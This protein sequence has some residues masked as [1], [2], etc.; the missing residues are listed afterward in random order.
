MTERTMTG[1]LAD[2]A[3]RHGSEPA[4]RCGETTVTFAGL[5]D[6]ARRVAAGLAAHGVGPGDR[7]ALWLPNAPAY[8]ALVFACARLGAIAVAVNTRFR[9]AEVEDIVGRSRAKA[10]VLWPGF[11]AIDFLGIL[12]A[13]DPDALAALETVV[14]YDEGDAAPAERLIGRTMV[15]YAELAAHGPMAEDFATPETGVAVFTTSGTTSKPKFVLHV[16]RSLTDHG[17][18]AG[19]ALGY[20]EADAVMLQALPLCGVF[21][22]AQAMATLAAARPMVLMPV[23]SGDEAAAAIE[24]WRVTHMN[25]SDEM[26]WRIF[27]AQD[28]TSR[29]LGSLR[30]CG[31][32]AFNTDPES[33]V[34]EADRRGVPAVGLYGMSE[35][36]ALFAAR[37]PAAPASERRKGGGTPVSDLARVRAR[38]PETGILRPDGE[39]GELE[40]TGPSVFAEYLDDPDAT[41]R[42][43]T[44]D[45][46]VRTGDLG[47]TEPGGGFEFLSRMGDV[48]RLGG[49]LV[50]PA[51][52]TA[53]LER[54]PAVAEAQAVG[55][56]A[57][58]G[59][60]V[61]AF[62]IPAPGAAFDE[63][64]LIAHCR[65]GMARFKVP[66][67]VFAV[68]AFPMA[69]SANGMKIQR[70]KLR[71][72]A[73]EADG[74]TSPTASSASART[75]SMS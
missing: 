55:V 41:A 8:L 17:R 72:W 20:G 44:D 39:P 50:N 52:I 18:D 12:G 21:G 29:D 74:N 71:A 6:E 15:R 26:Y 70:A 14:L 19:R 35:V 24:R 48:L 23:F 53:Y 1:F 22:F 61:A 27:E 47:V 7:V 57:A 75:G 65:A 60:Q 69:E 46:F 64:A 62:V 3:G 38:D 4:I 66:A 28:V 31:F 33:F 63:A 68:D 11:K 32:A 58:R 59:T 9:A 67:R 36:Q 40:L 45:G 34:A 25:G 16:Q 30:R 54:H 51:E 5:E 37:D 43:F 73:E 56:A 49:Y 10:L 13:V 42:T 2:L